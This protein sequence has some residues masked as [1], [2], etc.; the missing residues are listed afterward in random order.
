MM[1]RFIRLSITRPAAALLAALLLV[2]A[3]AQPAIAGSR[4]KDIA[5]FE[6]IRDNMLV[7]YGL[8]VGLDGTGD[9]LT[10]APFTKQSLQAMLERFG[11]NIRDAGT[12]RT[13]NLAA[14]MV[15][16]TLPAF[17]RQ[18]SRIDVSVSTMGDAKS[19]Q[20][21]TL[22]VTP[23]LGADGEVYGVAQGAVA[24]SGFK[25]QGAAATV[26][27]GV[28]TSGRIANGAIVE[29]EVGFDLASLPVLR[30]A[31]RNPDLTTARRISQAVSTLA[32]VP[33][34]RAL[35]PTTVNI[36]IP[37]RWRNDVIGFMTEIEQLQVEP[38]QMARVIIDERSGTIVMGPNVR[39]D[40]VAIAQGS[41]T[42]RITETPQVS[43]PLPFSPAATAIAGIAGTSAS[44]GTVQVPRIGPDGQ[45]VKDSS[46]NF[47]FDTITQ[48]VPGTGTPTVAGSAAGGAS[49]V[50]VPRTDIQ[51]DD[52]SNRRLGILPHGVSLRELVDG[53]NALGVGPRDMITI[54][55]AIKAAGAMQAELEVM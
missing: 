26:T 15:T 41:L 53:L 32:G 36:D 3:L 39:I 18:G 40:T 44:T 14:V 37:Q 28:P 1:T 43:Q 38:D 33:T 34:A 9:S 4:I 21:G 49:T 54:L 11:V 35:D 8:V 23:L 30:L 17:A 47:V 22:L 2:A 10:N 6:G 19:L 20:G 25:A 7:G 42:V 45:P 16:A 46:G 31:L 13:N 50:V 52:Q 27:R 12:Y 51:V 29:R 55:Q 5:D 24:I 48:A